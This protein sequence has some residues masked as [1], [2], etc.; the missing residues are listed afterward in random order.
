MPAGYRTRWASLR[1][2]W[3]SSRGL[4]LG[5]MVMLV[6]DAALPSL[7]LVSMG[8]A[9]GHI[10]GAVADGVSSAAGHALWWALA[11]A[12]GCF[13]LSMLRGPV[14]DVLSAA[15]RARLTAVLQERLVRAVSAP[16]GI[17]HLE[18]PAVLDRLSFAQGEVMGQQPADAPMTLLQTA[19]GRLGGLVACGVLSGYHW[20][21]GLTLLAAWLVVRRPLGALVRSRV[22]TF[23]AAGEPLRRSWYFL[24]VAWRPQFAKEVRVFGLGEWVLDS[25]QRWYTEAMRP[26]WRTVGRLNLRV[27]GAGLLVLAAY[28]LGAGTL[29]WDAYHHTV[30]LRTLATMLPMLLATMPVGSV[31]ATDFALESMLSALPDLDGL[32]AALAPPALPAPADPEAVAPA[33]VAP[34]DAAGLPRAAIRLE[35][36]GFRYPGGQQDVLHGL[37]LELPAGTSLAVVGVNGAGKTTLV[38][39]LARL[40]EPTAGRITVDG[41][42]LAD[43]DPAAWQRQLAVVFQDFTRYPLTAAE[44]VSLAL[45]HDPPDP[46]ALSRAAERAG[47]AELVEGLA[48]GWQT[49]LSPHYTGGTDLSGGQWQRLA[50]ARALYAVERGARVLVLDEPTAQLDVRAEAAFYDRFLQITEGTT[51]I[52][53][54]HRFST[55][56][57]ADRIA[58]LDAGRITELGGHDELLAAGGQYAELFRTQAARFTGPA[59]TRRGR[60]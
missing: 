14:E 45:R 27:A 4:A 1:L 33:A 13:T 29:S 34:A 9:A 24:G 57:K 22:G 36:V 48:N 60:Q 56:R 39:L 15:A 28:G 19:G 6:A 25:Y 40:R 10:P 47:A 21:L 35:G 53:I 59:S 54:S 12:A 18:D 8:R 46:G 41:H 23:R 30:G 7:T 43:L 26:S 16:P 20:W 3:G 2:L 44:N 31:T 49:V 17:A 52:V 51:S 37:D 5:A 50:L 11:L 55:V 38:T 32:E 42:D 58:V